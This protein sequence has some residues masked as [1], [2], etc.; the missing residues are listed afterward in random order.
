MEPYDFYR[1]TPYGL[2]YL[3]EKSGFEVIASTPTCG[4]WA[5]WVQ[6]LTD[7][8]IINYMCGCAKWTVRLMTLF[9]APFLLCGY[10][11]DKIFGRRGD[12]L[13]NL[14]V[15]IKSHD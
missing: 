3:A 12:T 8:I 7:T 13:D 1:Y 4:F 10:G 6:R 5:T 11:I 2:S 9:L 14:L 15:V